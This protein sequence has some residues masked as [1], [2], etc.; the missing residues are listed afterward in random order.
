MFG[1]PGTTE[2]PLL[3]NL[4]DYPEL[5]YIFHLH[6]G[7]AV[8]AANF[9]A[10]ASNTTALVSMHVAPGL[11]NAI[12]MIYGA[13]KNHS[14]MVVTA[15]AQDT[16]IRLTD[17][18]LGHDLV[19][20]AA[21]VTKWSVQVEHADEMAAI[22]QRAFKIANEHP[23]GPVFVALPINVMEQE[24]KT[25]ATTAGRLKNRGL[26]SA[27]TIEELANLIRN[28][29]K[30][31]IVAG[32][33][34]VTNGAREALVALSEKI[35]AG[36]HLE[37]VCGQ[38]PFPSKHPHFLGRVGPDS[39][40]HR[41]VLGDYDTLL[42][43]GG[44]FFE[45]VWHSDSKPFADKVTLIQI[46]LTES[47]L[48]H[49]FQLSLGVAADIK[50]TLECLLERVGNEPIYE[51]R[52]KALNES[53]LA[54]KQSTESEF[55][56]VK[57]RSPMTPER[58]MHELGLA[59]PKDVVISEESITCAPDVLRNFDIG[60][61]TPFYAPRGGGIGHGL[62][63]C[64]GVSIAHRDKQVI[65]ISGDGSAMYSI[66]GLWTAA[67]HKLDIMFVILSNREYRILKHNMNNYRRRFD[68]QSNGPYV[69]MDLTNPIL[70]FV[71]LAKGMGVPG[72]K[73]DSPYDIADVVSEALSVEGPY[74]LDLVVEGL[75]S[76]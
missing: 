53:F 39:E 43:I 73:I 34:V 76:N 45:D 5:E 30:I 33:D 1:N 60:G 36:V 12:G 21:P 16:R 56:K 69:F 10:Q 26:A 38:F 41:D 19:S 74:L 29:R 28:S 67:H 66:Q 72:R 18:L 17:P 22:M 71:E 51:E 59:L 50:D 46:E 49:N 13:M 15:G 64:L 8:G 31:G 23:K 48:A 40:A 25:A 35:G 65:A 52:C 2:T 14:P 63:G 27:E 62:C 61:R 9:Y 68:V 32:D 55:A 3:D 58:A 4:G 11:G 24:T 54:S 6:E 75:E 37:I 42:L 20:M 70:N 44:P 47:R 57:D 7:V